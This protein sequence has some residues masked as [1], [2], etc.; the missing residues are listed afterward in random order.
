[1]KQPGIWSERLP[2]LLLEIAINHRKLATAAIILLLAGLSLV[3]F[4]WG[5]ADVYGFLARSELESWH[6]PASE[7]QWQDALGNGLKALE[8]EPGNP[9]HLDTVGRIYLY[10]AQNRAI[11]EMRRDA[12]KA[13]A[14]VYI[15]RAFKQRPSWPYTWAYLVL[16]KLQ[17]KQIDA[18]FSHAIERA[19]TLG[20]WEPWVQ[21]VVVEA[22]LSSWK[23][24]D[25]HTRTLIVEAIDRTLKTQMPAMISKAKRYGILDFV[26]ARIPNSESRKPQFCPVEQ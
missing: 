14:V 7:Q 8:F 13:N 12:A 15:H 9:E 24:L 23:Q 4:R 11:D 19:V 25:T 18:E 26:C 2:P 1:M 6:Q 17:L 22:G 10:R 20:P 16:A 21:L 5:I 3:A